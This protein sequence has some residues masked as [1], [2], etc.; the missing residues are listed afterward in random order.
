MALLTRSSR[1]VRV[2]RLLLGTIN[3]QGDT[4]GCCTLWF[5]SRGA[6][7]AYTLRSADLTTCR[8]ANHRTESPADDLEHGRECV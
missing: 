1:Q 5:H 3:N 8:R 4:F 2:Q 7:W 6:C